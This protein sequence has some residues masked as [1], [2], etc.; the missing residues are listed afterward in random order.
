MITQSSLEIGN[1]S[2]WDANTLEDRIHVLIDG[3]LPDFFWVIKKF[4]LFHFF[5]AGLAFFELFFILFYL[6]E[7]MQAALLGVGLSVAFLT[8][9]TYFALKLYLQTQKPE[10]LA[11]YRDFFVESCKSAISFREEIPEHHLVLANACI[12]FATILEGKESQM[13]WAPKVFAF[14]T[15]SAQ[16][17]SIFCHRQDLY[18]MRELLLKASIEEHVKLVRLAP[19][20]LEVHAALA[21]AYVLLSSLYIN[22]NGPKI[23]SEDA[24]QSEKEVALSKEK[25]L[26]TAKKA[27]EEFKI[28]NDYAPH[29]PWV[30]LQLAYSYHDLGMPEEE[31]REYE[32]VLELCPE[33]K[34]TLFKL[35]ALYF[36]QGHNAKGLQI[37]E[38]L[39][40]SN[41]KKADEL[42][43]YYGH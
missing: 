10:K 7:M 30:H 43:A 37:Y 18:A 22:P 36:E 3:L 6:S 32:T 33:D 4:V 1:L 12:R 35:G 11:E 13:Y 38:E 23:E 9:F 2:G 41:F 5:F 25:F 28:I 39:R 24:L 31:I 26:V 42:L 29:D 8:F 19:T 20:D 40:K 21:N 15:P 17:F 16:R 14:L 27:I 34:E